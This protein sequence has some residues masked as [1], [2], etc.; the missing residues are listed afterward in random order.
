M[1]LLEAKLSIG[2]LSEATCD[3]HLSRCYCLLRDFRSKNRK[4]EQEENHITI[5][6]E[7]RECYF[8]VLRLYTCFVMLARPSSVSSALGLTYSL[9]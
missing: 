7:I 2:E 4:K 5:I 8:H 6:A 9:L 1:F 3:D